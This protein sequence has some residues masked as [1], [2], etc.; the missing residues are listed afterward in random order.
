M[1]GVEDGRPVLVDLGAVAPDLI[2]L[3][4]GYESGTGPVPEGVV[5][6]TADGDLDLFLGAFPRGRDDL[7]LLGQ[8]RVTG[9]GL[10]VLVEQ[11]DLA[12]YLMRSRLRG[13]AAIESFRR[14]RAGSDSAVPTAPSTE[15]GLR[16]RIGA[17]P[18][19]GARR[20]GSAP[21]PARASTGERLVPFTD[22]DQ[23]LARL[24]TVRSLFS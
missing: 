10:P 13:G 15:S 9:G 2:I 16:G 20:G 7:V 18:R 1:T 23:L 8:Q 6:R 12:A 22:R 24:R 11:A 17:P 14:L 3:A 5:P 19:R 21:Q 4:T